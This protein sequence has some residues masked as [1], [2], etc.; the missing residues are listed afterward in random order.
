MNQR[1]FL[2]Q[3]AGLC[4]RPSAQKNPSTCTYIPW[5]L[6]LSSAL[7]ALF[8]SYFLQV[9]LWFSVISPSSI[10]PLALS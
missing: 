7:R 9:A 4:S 8:K 5:T 1:R 10:L 6:E 2:L 3:G